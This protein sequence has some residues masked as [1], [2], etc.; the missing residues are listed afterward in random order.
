MKFSYSY[1]EN[2][3]FDRGEKKSIIYLAIKFGKR[4][5]RGPAIIYTGF[6]GEIYLNM[7]I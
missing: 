7:E 1:I 4:H 3:Y 2:R 5:I 6:N